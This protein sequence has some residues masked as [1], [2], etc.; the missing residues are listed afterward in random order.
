MM[1]GERRFILIAVAVGLIGLLA[2]PWYALED[3]FFALDWWIGFPFDRECAPLLVQALSFQKPWLWPLA[4][5][6]L[7][8]LAVRGRPRSDPLRVRLL[9][10]AGA[11]GLAYLLL[12][13]ILIGPLG[14]SLDPSWRQLGMGAGASLLFAAFLSMVAEGAAARGAM[15]GDHFWTAVLLG[16]VAGV[17]LFVL[18]P[19][20]A[21]LFR[22]LEADDGSFLPGPFLIAWLSP[23]LWSSAWHSLLL[24]VL[25]GGGTTVIGLLLALVAARTEAVGRPILRALSVLPIITPPFVIGLALILVFGRAGALTVFLEQRA[26]LPASRYIFGLPGVLLAQLLAFTPVSFLILVGSLE[27]LS[28]SL[29][30]A[31]AMLRARPGRIFW[32]VTLPLLRPGIANAFLVGFTESLADFGNPL[33]LGGSSFDVLATDVYFAVAGAQNDVPRAAAIATVLLALTLVAFVAQT[34]W[35]GRARYTTIGG[36]GAAG[37]F[38]PLPRGVRSLAVSVSVL[39]LA[40][41]VMVYGIVLF[42]GFFATLGRDATLTLAHYRAM[43]AVGFDRGLRWPG[44]A[45]AS[46]STTLLLSAIAAPLTAGL[47]LLVATLLERRRFVFRRAFELGTML[48]FAVPGTVIGVSYLLAFNEPPIELTGTALIL[49]ACFVTRNMP[50]GIRAGVASLAQLDPSLDEAS[51]MLG[52]RG[53]RTFHRILLPLL[54]PAVVTGLVS[55]FARAMTA[56]S[57][58][59]FLV[60][61]DHNLATTYILGRVEAGEYGSAI[62]YSSVLIL[63]M[64]AIILL[65]QRL[66]SAKPRRFGNVARGEE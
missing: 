48:S 31:A 43:F 51:F 64:L 37:R 57:A 65:T 1:R 62:A 16:S 30:E 22:A 35:L 66:D 44:G 33:V 12:Q 26:H 60:S 34:R 19:L 25:A 59:I 42:G 40:L 55:G 36:K 52:A 14:S 18:Y 10:G 11:G 47:G 61:A 54:R 13:G 53:A 17:L 49:L 24:A 50:V 5:P 7:A 46:F 45:W 27:G 21:L 29:E 38:A 15:L 39:W 56:V 20:L 6:V 8:P 63:L 3:G 28:P 58:V 9:L 32:T 4:A 2:V 41:T 23:K